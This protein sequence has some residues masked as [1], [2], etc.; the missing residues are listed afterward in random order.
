MMPLPPALTFL[1][2]DLIS[3]SVLGTFPIFIFAN[4]D[5]PN[6]LQVIVKSALI[7]LL[8]GKTHPGTKYPCL[9][10]REKKK[11]KN[12]RPGLGLG[13]T[14]RGTCPPNLRGSP[15]RGQN[16]SVIYIDIL[17]QYF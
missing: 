1:D 10:V 4:R 9:R 8:I 14:S 7:L 13:W 17:I 12:Y 3:G 15:Q 11:K 6:C 2:T 16:T 5:L